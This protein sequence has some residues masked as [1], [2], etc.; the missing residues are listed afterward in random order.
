[1]AKEQVRLWRGGCKTHPHTEEAFFRPPGHL[2]LKL[3]PFFRF[4]LIAEALETS[5][6]SQPPKVFQ[7]PSEYQSLA[8]VGKEGSGLTDAFSCACDIRIA[9]PSSEDLL[10]NQICAREVTKALLRS[11]RTG[12]QTV[13]RSSCGDAGDSRRAAPS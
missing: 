6:L 1:M 4:Q 5:V 8:P 13:T 7:L 10:A 11:R 2:R 12:S 9:S 3:M